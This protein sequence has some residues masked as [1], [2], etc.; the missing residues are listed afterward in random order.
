LDQRKFFDIDKYGKVRC[1]LCHGV[2]VRSSNLKKHVIT[3]KHVAVIKRV[4]LRKKQFKDPYIVKALENISQY[5]IVEFKEA[6]FFLELVQCFL[7]VWNLYAYF[8]R[9]IFSDILPIF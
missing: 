5:D 9:P 8:L 2:D 4:L 3:P 7:V 1:N 6:T